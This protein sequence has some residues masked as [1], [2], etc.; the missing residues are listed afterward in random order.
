ME[1]LVVV[2]ACE[3]ERVSWIILIGKVYLGPGCWLAELLLF[4]EP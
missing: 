4:I 2:V 1:Y 3:G